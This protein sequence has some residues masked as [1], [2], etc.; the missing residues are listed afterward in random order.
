MTRALITGIT[1]QDG[2]YLAKLLLEKGYEVT[3]IYRR[4]SSPNFWRLMSLGIYDDMQLVSADLT[5]LASIISAVKTAIPDEVYNLAAQSFVGTSFAQPFVTAEVNAI[6]ALRVL[7]AIRMLCPEARLYQA[8][9]SELFGNGSIGLLEE[10]SPFAPDSPYAVSKL[11]SY[12]IVKNYRNAYSL[13]TSNGILFNH[14]SPLRGL[15]FVTRKV[16]DAA[17][18]IKLELCENLEVGNLDSSRDWGYAPEYVEAMWMILQA[19]E[20][21]DFVIATGEKHTVRDLVEAAF[22]RVN[23]NWKDYI[24]VSEKFFRPTDV[25]SLCG[26]PAKAEKELGWKPKMKFKNL[27]NL[28]VDEDLRRWTSHL[29]GEPLHWDAMNV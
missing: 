28:M 20:P 26:N 2:A 6:G 8:S 24:V 10:T 7:E 17:A 5:D 12:W 22:G 19:D 13:F 18:R 11:F 15:E 3:G 1:G 21:D 4:S 29:A 9:T 14:E 23:L 16:T 25:N 27:V